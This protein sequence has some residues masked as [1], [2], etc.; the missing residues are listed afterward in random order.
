M[1]EPAKYLT[2][3]P[4]ELDDVMTG[5]EVAYA[6]RLSPGMVRMALRRGKIAGRKAHAGGGHGDVWLIRRADAE[7]VWGRGD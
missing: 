2:E 7:R 5:P 4:K 6:Y 3:Y 1:P